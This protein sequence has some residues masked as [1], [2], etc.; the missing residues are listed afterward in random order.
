M[1]TIRERIKVGDIIELNQSPF[2]ANHYSDSICEGSLATVT[3]VAK[4][5]VYVNIVP[6]ASK[7]LVVW[8]WIE[9]IIGSDL[10][11]L[12]NYIIPRIIDVVDDI[13]ENLEDDG[14]EFNLE[15]NYIE[16]SELKVDKRSAMREL[17]IDLK[18]IIAEYKNEVHG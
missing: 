13:I 14:T 4:E 7:P 2:S 16:V 12:D 9:R 17:E 18:D 3:K 8:D 15:G 11:H 5:G 1:K 10:E 6:A